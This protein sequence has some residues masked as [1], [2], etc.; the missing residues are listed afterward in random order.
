MLT[1]SVP[2]IFSGYFVKPQVAAPRCS[3]DADASADLASLSRT[4]DLFHGGERPMSQEPN[5]GSIDLIRW[6]FT[7]NPTHRDEIR[8]HLADMGLDVLVH[9]EDMFVVT[10]EEPDNTAEEVIEEI[11]EI[12]GAPFDVTQEDFHRVGLHT[13]HHAEDETAAQA[14]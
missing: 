2:Q 8:G 9:G 10:W 3:L 5:T 6:T 7:V 1:A 13:Y 14:A 12:N 11:W 4:H